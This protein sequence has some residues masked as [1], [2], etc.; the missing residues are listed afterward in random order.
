MNDFSASDINVPS[1]TA[2]KNLRECSRNSII[3]RSFV[4]T[5]SSLSRYPDKA[6]VLLSEQEI[7]KFYLR[8]LYFYGLLKVRYVNGCIDLD[9]KLASASS[10]L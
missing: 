2:S 9:V 3:G 4:E 5:V 10:Y 1:M 8:P 7:T 6:K